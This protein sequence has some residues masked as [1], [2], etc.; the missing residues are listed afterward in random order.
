MQFEL[1]ADQAA[2]RE[3]A[4][5][6][7]LEALA[8]HAAAWDEDGYFPVDTLRE[9]AGLGLASIYVREDVGGSGMTRLDAA[10]LFEELSAGCTSTAAYLSIHNMVSWMIDTFG[11]EAQRTLAAR[12]LRHAAARQLLPDRA[13]LRLR[14]RVLAHHGAGRGQQRLCP[15]R[16][17]GSSRAPGPTSYLVMCRTGGEG[18]AGAGSRW[19]RRH[20][21]PGVRQA[22]RRRW[23]GAPSPPRSSRSTDVGSPWPTDRRGGRRVQDRHARPG[24]RSGQHRRLL[25]GCRPRLPGEG[26][27]GL[28]PGT[29]PV[30]PQ[31][32]RLPGTAVPSRRH[33]DRARRRPAMVHRAAASLD[34]QPPTPRCI[35]RWPSASPPMSASRWSTRRCSCMAATATSRTMAS[36]ATCATA[37]CIRSSRAP[38]RS[39]G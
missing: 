31:A 8:P 25:A 15:G 13:R 35:A 22:R 27:H 16:Q 18:P 23:A 9:A 5:A 29:P 1:T 32:R 7:A 17:Q 38:T 4:R 11:D 39:C 30:R 2:V 12:S 10:I 24:R 37:A 33:G 28:S 20:A 19:S 21:G 3:M 34:A 14:R 26:R 6:F 36:S